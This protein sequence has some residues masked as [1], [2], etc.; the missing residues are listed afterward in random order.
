M[1]LRASGIGNM[2]QIKAATLMIPM[3]CYAVFIEF[4]TCQLVTEMPLRFIS[5]SHAVTI[6]AF[7]GL[8]I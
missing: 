8:Q 2:C 7:V 4:W 3:T 6:T 5:V 1:T